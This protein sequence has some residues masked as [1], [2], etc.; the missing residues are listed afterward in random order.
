[1][2][3]VTGELAGGHD[4][5]RSEEEVKD[6]NSY[7][8]EHLSVPRSQREESPTMGTVQETQPSRRGG[9][10]ICREDFKDGVNG[11]QR[12]QAQVKCVA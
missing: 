9:P 1:M 6:G 5:Q 12:P 2:G 11:Q 4:Q 8:Q 3:C 7:V 10:G